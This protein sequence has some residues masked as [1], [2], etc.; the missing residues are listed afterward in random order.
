[1]AIENLMYGPVKLLK[2]SKQKAFEEGMRLLESVGLTD[3][4]NS[5]PRELSGHKKQRVAIAR[6]LA[7]HPKILL[8]DE[9]TSALDP[10]MVG[11]VLNVIK[12]LVAEEGITTLIMTHEMRFS[13]EISPRVLFMH[14]GKIYEEGTPDQIF[15]HPKKDATIEFVRSLHRLNRAF[16]GIGYDL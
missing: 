3:K 13:E 10:T 15:H 4:A 9:P 12:R 8:F 7:M 2:Q 16:N 14:G 11:E 5:F 1:M 6:A